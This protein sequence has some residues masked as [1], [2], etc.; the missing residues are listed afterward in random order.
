MSLVNGSWPLRNSGIQRGDRALS[1]GRLA[2]VSYPKPGQPETDLRRDWLVRA[3]RQYGVDAVQDVSIDGTWSALRL[4]PAKD[5]HQPLTPDTT[6][7]YEVLASN[8]VGNS[9]PSNT[10]TATTPV[11]PLAVS[12]LQ[13]G[14]I[15]TTSALLSWVL[16]SSNDTGVQVWRRSG[17]A[18]SFSLVTTLPADTTNF[19]DNTLQP[20][21]LY[22]YQVFAIDLAGSSP[23]ADTGLTTLALA[24]VVTAT[25]PAGQVQL[26]WPASNGAVAYNI[27]RGLTSGGE[28]ASPYA[29]V[30]NA[31]S[32]TDAGVTSGQAY[33][34]YVTAVDF[35][36][37]STPSNEVTAAVQPPLVVVGNA[38]AITFIR[39]SSAVAVAPY[40]TVTDPSYANL[41][42]ASV[43]LS[44]G[45]LDA[46]AETLAA[47][48]A[49]TS[50]T[51]A[52]NSTSGV[53]TLS[54]SDTLAH[55]QQVLRSVTYVDTLKTT[56][57][58]ANRALSFSISD[59]SSVSTPVSSSVAF[60]VAPQIVGVYVSGSAW[61]SGLFNALAAA[62]AGN[63]T[64]GYELASGAGQLS[65]ANVV[66]W[67]NVN[68]ISIVFSKPVSGVSLSSLSLGDSSNNGGPSSGITVSSETNPSTTV[69]TFTVSGPLTSNK[70][71][72]ALAAAGI[73]DAAGATLDGE[74]TTGVSTFAAGSGDG[75]PGG[76][77]DFR[78]NVLAGDVNGDG[79]VSAAD[80]TAMRSQALGPDNATNWRYDVNGD[81][82]VSAVDV[83][84]IRSQPLT[85]IGSFPDP[86]VPSTSSSGAWLSARLVRNL[87]WVAQAASSSEASDQHHKK[88]VA[89][90]ALEAVFAQY[91]Q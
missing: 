13:P 10:A 28:G 18:G 82:K 31:T 55:Y 81:G 59:A 78:F 77:F 89:I 7:S 14:N 56:T 39:G 69:A 50:I 4:R 2:W 34:Y 1:A 15:A 85:A 33:Y 68:T 25:T 3:L 40:L 91:G 11:P 87:A 9:V 8:T 86:I 22:E 42:S 60:D 64:L 57:N 47:N 32:F 75:A 48:T 26:S 16:N 35:S 20:G 80:V 51:A 46:G 76:N 71:Y 83:N 65:N 12:Q 23:S 72:L 6:Y 24:P 61:N 62:G 73:T 84:V 30:N 88:D 5:D 63:A 49:G 52:Y 79:E 45:P 41:L 53:L 27:Y 17:G 58:T 67:V 29:I 38:G 70:Y 21:T 44:G 66:G 43:T 19:T 37:E 36:G 54:G 74:W 90:E